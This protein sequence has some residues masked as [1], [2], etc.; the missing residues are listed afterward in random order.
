MTPIRAQTEAFFMSPIFVNL[1]GTGLGAPV[2]GNCDRG[3]ERGN[4]GLG[5]P[6]PQRYGAIRGSTDPPSSV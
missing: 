1:K 2:R 3:L 4:R 5:S 6:G